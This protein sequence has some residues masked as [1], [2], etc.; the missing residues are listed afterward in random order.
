M[1]PMEV[2]EKGEGGAK[3]LAEAGQIPPN[4]LRARLYGEDLASL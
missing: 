2:R 1:R 4:L 3:D